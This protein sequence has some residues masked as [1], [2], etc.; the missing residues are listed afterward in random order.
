MQQSC[1]KLPDGTF[2]GKV[3]IFVDT[4]TFDPDTYLSSTD[5]STITEVL[6]GKYQVKDKDGNIVTKMGQFAEAVVGNLKAGVINTERLIVRGVNILDK[7]NQQDQTI[8]DLKAANLK[9]QHQIDQLNASLEELK[10]T[11]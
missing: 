6:N 1:F 8:D 10:K 2:V 4:S 9:Q 11:R 3:M 7:L 5:G